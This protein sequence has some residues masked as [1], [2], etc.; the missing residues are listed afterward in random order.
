MRDNGL[1]QAVA[2]AAQLGFT[3]ACPLLVF[4][5]GGAW[6]DN[7]LGTMPWLLF[8]GILLGIVFAGGA[9]YRLSTLQTR[10]RTGGTDPK[11]P[12]KVEREREGAGTIRAVKQ[13]RNRRSR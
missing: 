1:A 13:K 7:R 6:L 5:G 4:I 2:L 9:M 8:A 3:I 12:Y 11:A 10:K